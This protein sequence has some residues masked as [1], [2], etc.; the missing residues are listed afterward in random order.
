MKKLVSILSAIAFCISA[1]AQV[2]LGPRNIIKTNLTG[3]GLYTITANYEFKLNEQFSVGM[4]GGYKIPKT[5]TLE[6]AASSTSSNGD[7]AYTGQITPEGFFLNP[8]AR[9]YSNGAMTGFY[10]EV[11]ARYYNYSFQIPYDYEKNGGTINAN[12]DGTAN[13]VG[14]GLVIGTQIPLGKI[15]VLDLFAGLGLGVGSAHAETNDPNLDAQDFQDI[16]AEMDA[17]E[18]V[19]IIFI[20]KAIDNM[21]YD[22]N[23]TSAWADIE[24]YTLPIVRGG[25]SFGIMF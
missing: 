20:G 25:I 12:A 5:Y 18:Q 1:S 6:A 16:K 14:G 2:D 3:L 22:A 7:L 17:I 13:G 10:L 9:M 21:T 4:L 23:A 19:D 8:Y 15:F 11:F 24:N